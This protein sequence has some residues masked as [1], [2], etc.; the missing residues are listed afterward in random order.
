MHVTATDG[1]AAI[2]DTFN[3]TVTNQIASVDIASRAGATGGRSLA[4]G[5]DGIVYGDTAIGSGLNG[6]RT[7]IARTDGAETVKTDE[8]TYD[9]WGGGGTLLEMHDVLADADVSATI[10]TDGTGRYYDYNASGPQSADEILG[11][12][13]ATT[14][15]TDADSVEA[16]EVDQWTD[17]GLSD[18]LE[19]YDILADAQVQLLLTP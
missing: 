2:E 19:A 16:T 12:A 15:V 6:I 7:E 13:S 3:V 17:G 8:R 11:V 4:A 9:D 18:M 5:R 1:I 14:E 10:R